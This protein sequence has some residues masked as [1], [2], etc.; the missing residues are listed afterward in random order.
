MGLYST[1]QA[2]SEPLETRQEDLQTAGLISR[3]RSGIEAIQPS[4]GQHVHG[5][6]ATLYFPAMTCHLSSRWTKTMA[7][8]LG[9]HAAAGIWP[10]ALEPN[11]AAALL[12][13]FLAP[14]AFP[15]SI[16][17][18]SDA[19]TM[20]H[21]AHFVAL[22]PVCDAR[23][24]HPAAAHCGKRKS[25]G[26]QPAVPQ[27][28]GGALMVQLYYDVPGAG[29][30]SLD[31]ISIHGR[32]PTVCYQPGVHAMRAGPPLHQEIFQSPFCS[33]SDTQERNGTDLAQMRLQ[34]DQLLAAFIRS[35]R[36]MNHVKEA[37]TGTLLMFYL[38]CFS[39]Q[40]SQASKVAVP[41][42]LVS[43]KEE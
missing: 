6:V 11:G 12:T 32:A 1:W 7:H 14:A 39:L 24:V 2:T 22:L 9:K 4:V 13:R 43:P 15:P 23:C 37:A 16:A 31:Y 42:L 5:P 35:K 34:Q 3:D 26:A 25:F 41:F 19:V 18:G 29:S 27:I 30:E 8:K 33:N 40:L 28:S 36:D 10:L 20:A 17:A 21:C 38:K